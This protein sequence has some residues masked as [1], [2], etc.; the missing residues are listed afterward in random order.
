M[1]D[2]SKPQDAHV[3]QRL[4]TEPMIWLSS[5]R[6]DGRPHL[7]PV[8]FLWDGEHILIYSQPDRQKM[9]N[10][11]HNQHVMLALDTAK[12]GEDIVMIE[13]T[14]ELL[15]SAGQTMNLPAF[16]EKYATRLQLMQSDPEALA[17]EYS[18]E[19]RITPTKF[20]SWSD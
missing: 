17:K 4:R 16:V 15:E 20:I 13:G 9:R 19:I 1:L 6:P 3:D 2:L 5:V 8:W 7:V 11:R 18:R 12:D 14:A 10:L